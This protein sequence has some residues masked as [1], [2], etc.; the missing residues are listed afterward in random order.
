MGGLRYNIRNDLCPNSCGTC[1]Q[2]TKGST[3]V[4]DGC[5]DRTITINGL[6]CDRAASV[7]YC[8]AMT[9]LGN[10]GRDI[11]MKSCGYCVPEPGL[12]AL[13]ASEA[14]TYPTP[15]RVLGTQGESARAMPEDSSESVL[16]AQV[17]EEE[18]EE[19]YAEE[20]AADALEEGC[21]DDP[22][23]MDLDG[24][25]CEVYSAFIKSGKMSAEEACGYNDGEARRNCRRVCGECDKEPQREKCQDLACV[26]KWRL[27]YGRCFRC[28]QWPSHCGDPDFAADCPK[29][30][31]TC[32]P[33]PGKEEEE[34]KRAA[35]VPQRSKAPATTTTEPPAAP[36]IPCRD[37]DCV[38]HWLKE[39][40]ECYQ[41]HEFSDTF[42]GRDEEFM[43]ACPRSCKMCTPNREPSCED[44]FSPHTC[45]RLAAWQWCGHGRVAEHCRASCGLCPT[46]PEETE[47]H[48]PWSGPESRFSRC[49]RPGASVAYLLA[50]LGAVAPLVFRRQ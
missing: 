6:S 49:S 40:G 30:C 10:V 25:T 16:E 3:R 21:A 28:E 36:P 22:G 7:G 33:S 27:E 26:M 46:L 20:Q 31:G 44:N 29:T 39:T 8:D 15:K 17:Q 24:D 14:Y 18:E 34:A 45:R 13:N 23:W 1:D 47:G 9:N 50:L 2:A 37:H 35:A 38:D 41:C 12:K 32:T 5:A 11:C 48:P 43:E 42:C 19:R 4:A